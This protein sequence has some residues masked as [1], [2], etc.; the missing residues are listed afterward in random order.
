MSTK[1]RF[2]KMQGAGNDF[3]MLNGVSQTIALT[4]AQLRWLA[5]RRFGIGADQILLVQ[6][7]A[8]PDVDFN[9]R[10]FNSDGGE[11]EHCGN[12]ARCFAVFVAEEGLSN[13]AL[14]RVRIQTGV[15]LIEQLPDG[16]VRVNMGAPQFGADVVDFD[17]T[18]LLSEKT[19]SL[20]RWSLDTPEGH[21]ALS[22]VSMGNPHAVQFVKDVASAPVATLGLAVQSHP[23]FA[24]GVN[25]GFLQMLDRSHAKIRVYER[26]AGETLACGT[27]ICAAAVAAMMHGFAENKL[28]LQARGGAVRVEWD[29]SGPLGLQAPVFMTGPATMVFSGEITIPDHP[30]TLA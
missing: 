4:S 27:G 12:G 14:L 19:E 28:S 11:V 26:G 5:D 15:I 9:Y 8:E 22:L 29:H 21:A 10:I 30:A 2:S 6:P 20:E 17:T 25:A 24:K 1:I 7:A 16:Q 3:V 18:N 23:R 13:K